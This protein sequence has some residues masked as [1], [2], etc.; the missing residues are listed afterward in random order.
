MPEQ[1]GIGTGHYGGNQGIA[2]VVVR[3]RHAPADVA[4]DRV[5]LVPEYL[6]LFEATGGGD[7]CIARAKRFLTAV[8]LDNNACHASVLKNEPF[9]T[10]IELQRDVTLFQGQA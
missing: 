10:G 6:V 7:D 2:Y 8:A 4:G 5:V 9:E 3:Y 1:L